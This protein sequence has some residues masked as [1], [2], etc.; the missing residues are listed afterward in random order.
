MSTIEHIDV[1]I[2]SADRW[3]LARA[4]ISFQSL[5]SWDHAWTGAAEA[6]EPL[7][8]DG[9]RALPVLAAELHR[10]LGNAQQGAVWLHNFVLTTGPSV[11]SEALAQQAHAARS[12]DM[13][14][15]ADLLTE[16]GGSIG[17]LAEAGYAGFVEAEAAEHLSISQQLTTIL[18]GGAGGDLTLRMRCKLADLTIVAGLVTAVVPPHAHAT[19]IIAAGAA[20]RRAWH[21]RKLDERETASLSGQTDS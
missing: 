19:G 21:C 11:L 15:L 13:A 7:N 10:G 14:D 12:N 1:S 4:A 5:I 3:Q 20:A 17:E 16:F 9:A 18:G 6:D 2:S 8:G